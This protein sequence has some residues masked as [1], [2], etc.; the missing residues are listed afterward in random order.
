MRADRLRSR[1]YSYKLDML[2][3]SAQ[4]IRRLRKAWRTRDM[5]AAAD[6]LRQ[7][8]DAYDYSC[9]HMLCSCVCCGC[10]VF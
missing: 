4:L 9:V 2:V 6:V 5:E 7:A 8:A 1:R 3:T 10:L